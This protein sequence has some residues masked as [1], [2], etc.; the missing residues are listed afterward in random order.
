MRGESA[1]LAGTGAKGDADYGRGGSG[2]EKCV[3]RRGFPT[4]KKS[5]E[6]RGQYTTS[7]GPA[8]APHRD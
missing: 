1:A 8:R 4:R 6:K 7:A 2:D 5:G 3:T